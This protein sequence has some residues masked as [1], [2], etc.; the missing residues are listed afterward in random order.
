MARQLKRLGIEQI[1]LLKTVGG[2][3]ADVKNHLAQKKTVTTDR[4]YQ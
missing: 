4:A 3:L 1:E 2:H